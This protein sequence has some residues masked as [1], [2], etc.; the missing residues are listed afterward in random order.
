[1]N[2]TAPKPMNPGIVRWKYA[3][4]AAIV[5]GLLL[6]F[7]F[8][9]MDALLR[10]G[11]IMACELALGAKVEIASVDFKF[12]NLS[13]AVR[14]FAA[15]NKEAPLTNLVEFES[16]KLAVKPLPLLSKKINIDEASVTGVRWGTAR[17]TSGALPP[18]KQ[19]SYA[20]RLAPPD[21]PA[22]KLLAK[23]ETQ[24]K[25]EWDALPAWDSIQKTKDQIAN[26]SLDGVVKPENLETLKQ[27]EALKQEAQAKASDYRQKLQGLDVGAKLQAVQPALEDLKGLQIASPQDAVAAKSKIE[28]AQAKIRDLQAVQGQLQ[29]LKAQAEADFAQAGSLTQKLNE[30]KEK[31]L[32]GLASSLNL[33]SLSYENLTRSLVGPVWL[34][35][36]RRFVE[37][38]N[39][40]RRYMPPRKEKE[41]KTTQPRLH[42]L[43]VSFPRASVPPAFLIQKLSLTGSTG[44]PG[45]TG[46]PVEFVGLVTNITSD[47]R[48]LGLPT[49][50]EIKGAQSGRVYDLLAVLDHTADVP[51]DTVSLSGQGLS[52]AALK[53]PSSDYLPRLDTGQVAF[54]S[55]FTLEGDRLAADLKATVSGMTAPDPSQAQDQTKKL[56]AELWQGVSRVNLQASVAG[57]GDDLQFS[58]T[59]DLDRL[60]GERLK[61]MA[62]EKLAEVRAKLS[63]EIDKYAAVKQKELLDQYGLSRSGA[64]GDIASTQNS[65]QDKIA[66]IQNLIQEKQNAAQQAVD[67]QKKQAEEEAKKKAQEGLNKLFG[68]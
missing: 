55:Q 44:G 6:A 49:K 61:T 57:S 31:D 2:A 64:L 21:S 46:E 26:L 22:G 11:L 3:V 12:S 56:V 34:S 20:A 4:P 39:T 62:G 28:N 23:L 63:A 66:A 7:Y 60:L 14:G 58:L 36:V 45:K 29:Q 25:T 50:A 67:Q 54:T 51:K 47:P 13:L 5:I 1:M 43:D 33:P 15:A 38:S 24:A 16:A 19:K 32:A 48:L 17:K 27:A 65:V 53:L 68:K 8:F 18:A 9:F 10:R 52:S 35:R 40:A 42:G 59:S 37:L 41:T 30:W